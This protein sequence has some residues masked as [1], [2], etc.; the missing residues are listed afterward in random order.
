MRVLDAIQRAIE[1]GRTEPVNRVVRH[2]RPS[3]RQEVTRS[4]HEMLALIHAT[5][6]GRD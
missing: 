5:P 4:P 1:T 3:K 2:L 6:P